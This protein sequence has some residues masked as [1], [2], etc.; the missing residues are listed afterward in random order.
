M[1]RLRT[2]AIFS[3]KKQ[4]E[5]MAFFHYQASI[6]QK[7][8]RGYYSR[9]YSHDFFARKAYILVGYIVVWSAA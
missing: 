7:A 3:D 5:R 6:I 8:F 1:G 9:R 4:F 2:N